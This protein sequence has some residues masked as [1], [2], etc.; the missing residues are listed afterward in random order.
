MFKHILIPTDGSPASEATILAAIE[1]AR[2]IGAAVTGIHV[3]PPFFIFNYMTGMLAE[4]KEQFIRDNEQR[5]HGVLDAVTRAAAAA[6]VRCHT[7][8]ITAEHPHQAILAAAQE[9]ACDLIAM[10]SHGHKGVRALL[11][12]S[13]TQKVLTHS[14]VPVLIYRQSEQ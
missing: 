1:F 2:E 11:L 7:M 9:Q 4:T 10:A 5:A 13:E 14:P 3:L 8:Q 12:G 6:G